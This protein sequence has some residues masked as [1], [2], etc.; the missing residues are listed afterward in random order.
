MKRIRTKKY[1]KRTLKKKKNSKR[2]LKNR[3][4]KGTLR[5]RG[6]DGEKRKQKKEQDIKDDFRNKFMDFFK[7]L[8][9][10]VKAGELERV[11]KV[12]E[13]FN[14]YFKDDEDDQNG[15]TNQMGINTL[16]PITNGS[17]PINKKDYDSN[18]PLIA[19]VPCLVVI[20]DNIDDFNIRKAFIKIFIENKGNIN[21]VSYTKNISALSSAIKLQDK[22]LVKHLLEK[23][24]DIN[25]LTEDQR[26]LLENL[27]KDEE[28]EAI[29]HP[30]PTKPIVELA[31]P[32]D[33]PSDSG[34][35][36][37]VEPDFWK[38]IFEENEM[39][40]I[41]NKIN[42][43]MNSDGN[44]P[45]INKKATQLW[46]VC[47]INKAMIHTYF[48]PKK[49]EL[50]E[51]FGTFINDTDI[52]FSHYNIVLCAALIV[53][54]II[55]E[56]MIG[57]NYTLLFKGGKAIQLVLAGIPE[58]SEYKTEDIDVL[59]M[60]NKN[61]PY[62]EANIKNLSGH[63]AYLIRWFLNTS[64]TQYNVSVQVPNLSN[65]R[66]NPFIFKLSYLKVTKKRNYKNEMVDDFKQFSDI[67]FKET[68]E[69]VKQYFENSIAYK[70]FI[71][72]LNQTVLFRCP[73]L[74]SLLNEKLYYYA[75]YFKFKKMLEEKKPIQETEYKNLTVIECD[76]L[77]EKFERA[78]LAMNEGLQKRRASGLSP[79]ELLK[80]ERSYIT[81]RLDNLGIKDETLVTSIVEKI[82][83]INILP[84]DQSIDIK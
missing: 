4:N 66:A 47:A 30:T 23:G 80:K 65:V 53:F 54:G 77:M 8:Q 63:L 10:A 13:N 40:S 56:K 55:S 52:D 61:E 25:L 43:M 79:D 7:D 5:L 59:I 60:P 62:V 64:E 29:I 74:G 19:F 35:N 21:L 11:Q 83:G 28:I 37:E 41:R 48:I 50:Y 46:S 15:Q 14:N 36:P 76:R 70:F 69:S 45:I 9:S 82:Y 44:I 67:D 72:E 18:T 39:L 57:Q 32:I 38:P 34:Y 84:D 20:F 3:K 49:N 2:T 68:P 71:S 42:E 16:I 12:T 27:L 33:L 26:D 78:I 22:E 51:S 24:A 31:L 73:N 17:I 81:S 58:T 75:K 6:G 1:F